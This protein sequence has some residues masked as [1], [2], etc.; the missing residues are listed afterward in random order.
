V[1][2]RHHDIVDATFVAHGDCRCGG[3]DPVPPG[4]DVGDE[5]VV[6]GCRPTSTPDHRAAPPPRPGVLEL[7][8]NDA[9]DAVVEVRRGRPRHLSPL[10]DRADRS[11][12][13]AHLVLVA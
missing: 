4:A 1:Q 6:G 3:H 10:H 2:R 9:F 5:W 11:E 7:A 13:L 12:E 8:R